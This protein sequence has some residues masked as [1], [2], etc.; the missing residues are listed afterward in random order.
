MFLI[1]LMNLVA[2][3]A[4]SGE[5]VVENFAVGQNNPL[6]ILPKISLV[7]WFRGQA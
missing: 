3:R 2:A 7:A 6:K 5:F 4:A 1:L